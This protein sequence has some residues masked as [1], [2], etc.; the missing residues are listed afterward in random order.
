MDSYHTTVMYVYTNQGLK[1]VF[2]IIRL[3]IIYNEYFKTKFENESF[4]T[5]CGL[6]TRT[7]FSIV[8]ID[9]FFSLY[10]TLIIYTA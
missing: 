9:E 10:F 1:C 5:K 6:A 4:K 3:I 7:L 8:V 2:M